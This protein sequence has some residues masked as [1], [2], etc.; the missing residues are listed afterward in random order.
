MTSGDAECVPTIAMD[1]DRAASRERRFD[2]RLT[3]R[4]DG[5]EVLVLHE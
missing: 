3:G 4:E 5:D 2:K 1:E